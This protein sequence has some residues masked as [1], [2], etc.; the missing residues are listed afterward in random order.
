[1]D[2]ASREIIRWNVSE[3]KHTSCIIWDLIDWVD[4]AFLLLDRVVGSILTVAGLYGFLWGEKKEMEQSKNGVEEV[5]MVEAN[6]EDNKADLELQLVD[7]S[8]LDGFP[9]NV[10]RELSGTNGNSHN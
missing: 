3:E 1:M 9:I 5:D 6:K 8:D 4:F 7:N 2:S 10:Q